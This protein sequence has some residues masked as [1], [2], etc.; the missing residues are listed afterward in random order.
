MNL[1]RFDT[2]DSTNAMARRLIA[3]GDITAD[4]C[5]VAREQ[6]AGRGTKTRSWVSPRDAGL[7]MSIVLFDV[8]A[9]G[10][11]MQRITL[12]CG[13]ASA[14][15]LRSEFAI[16]IRVKPI[17]DLILQGGKLGGILTEANM[18]NDAIAS[19][20]IGVGVNLWETDLGDVA[21][22]MG[23]AFIESAGVDLSTCDPASIAMHIAECIAKF[24]R[25]IGTIPESVIDEDWR[26]LMIDL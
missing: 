10:M 15:T 3:S 25:S 18:V 8:T 11:S 4:A 19:L 1:L 21:A 9:R 5:L 7:Y 24:V 14:Q 17:N 20:I 12:A 2:L 26:P 13:I 16:D 6:T 22:P 23:P